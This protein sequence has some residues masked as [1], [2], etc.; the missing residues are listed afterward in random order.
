MQAIV[1]AKSL[2]EAGIAAIASGWRTGRR[3]EPAADPC[4]RS[5]LRSSPA[6]TSSDA[7]F[8]TAQR[9]DSCEISARAFSLAWM[10]ASAP[11]LRLQPVEF[12]FG[13]AEARVDFQLALFLRLQ[14]T[15][16]F[17]EFYAR[18][19]GVEILSL[20]GQRSL[21]IAVGDE[22]EQVALALDRGF[23]LLPLFEAAQQEFGLG[24]EA[25]I[26]RRRRGNPPAPVSPRRNRP[27]LFPPPP[28]P[29]RAAP[30]PCPARR[31]FPRPRQ[32]VAQLR[33]RGLDRPGRESRAQSASRGRR[34]S[35]RIR[36]CPLRFS[37]RASVFP[38][39]PRQATGSDRHSAMR[40]YASSKDAS[41]SSRSR[42]SISA[43][44]R[45]MSLCSSPNSPAAVPAGRCGSARRRFS[46]APRGR[47]P[48][49]CRVSARRASIRRASAAA[50]R[51][52]GGA[53]RIPRPALPVSP[54]RRQGAVPIHA[55]WPAGDL[56]FRAPEAG[57]RRD[58]ARTPWP[59]AAKV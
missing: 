25:G 32:A 23:E 31:F 11:R 12:A 56:K 43:N 18:N 3:R 51:S 8:S 19:I 45:A 59:A 26:A 33:H 28:P 40:F 35:A 54:K 21:V 42:A 20:G 47:R 24:V 57:G 53:G 37:A 16:D 17:I 34:A 52:A 4:A 50:P 6:S 27:P 36:R 55:S 10:A 14:L 46:P 9:R 1:L 44:A 39:R 22:K 15:L 58:C 13:E 38:P 48:A 7:S 30:A 5:R 2:V 41:S 49:P 29:R